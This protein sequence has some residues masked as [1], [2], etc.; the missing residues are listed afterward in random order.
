MALSAGTRIGPYE[1]VGAIGAIGAGPVSL[2]QGVATDLRYGTP[3]FDLSPSGALVYAPQAAEAVLPAL[4]SID[5]SGK[6]ETLIEDRHFDAEQTR[7]SPDGRYVVYQS[8]ANS[9]DLDLWTYDT[10]ARSRSRLT[11][12]PG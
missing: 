7:L 3:M 10:A 11:N 8:V 12:I 1:I 6:A 4:Q 9:R 2:L 5:R